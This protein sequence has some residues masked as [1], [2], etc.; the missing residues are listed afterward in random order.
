[1]GAV[2]MVG[3]NLEGETRVLTT[4]I[5]MYTQMGRFSEALSLSAILL[6]L[7]FAIAATLTALQQSGRR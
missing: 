3:G 5:L 4:G 6:G 7:T 2:T 1:V